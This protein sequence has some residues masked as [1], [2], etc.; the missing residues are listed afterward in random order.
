LA[1]SLASGAEAS[2]SFFELA[3]VWFGL[4]IFRP[5]SSHL[6]IWTITI[7]PINAE[8]SKLKATPTIAEV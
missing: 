5:R 7:N 6:L 1:H 8:S 3:M 2:L 4:S